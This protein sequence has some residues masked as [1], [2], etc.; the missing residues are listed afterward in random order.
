MPSSLSDDRQKNVLTF[1]D[2]GQFQAAL[3]L[4]YSNESTPPLVYT[5]LLILLQQINTL[6][7]IHRSNY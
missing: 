3:M 2:N 1:D 6:F 4:Q 7:I 5:P